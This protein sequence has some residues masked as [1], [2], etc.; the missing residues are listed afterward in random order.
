MLP[1]QHLLSS[2]RQN[3]EVVPFT[4]ASL[5]QRQKQRDADFVTEMLR[6]AC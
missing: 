2:V 3:G 6:A 5:R 1:L 4:A